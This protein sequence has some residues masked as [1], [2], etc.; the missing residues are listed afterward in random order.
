MMLH[1]FSLDSLDSQFFVHFVMLVL[2]I[3]L[4]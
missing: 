3:S 1:R 4:E 2:L